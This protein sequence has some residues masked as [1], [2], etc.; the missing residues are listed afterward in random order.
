MSTLAQGN[1]FAGIT[2]TPSETLS[3]TGR[4]KIAI[5]GKPKAGKST[6]AT[7]A[8]TP[9]L[10]YDWDDRPESLAGKPGL[11]VKSRRDMMEVET[12]LS[13]LKAAHKQ[14][15]PL[16]A[17]VVHDSVTYLNKAME[18]EIFRQCKDFYKEIKVGQSTTVKIRKGW[19]TINGIQ[20]YIQYLIAEY[21]AL[22]LDLIFVFHEKN[23][24]DVVE[25]TAERTE[26][27]GQLTTDPQYLSSCLSLFNEVY[28]IK[29]EPN[30]NFVTECRPNLYGNWSTTLMLDKVE[31]PNIM[32]MIEKHESKRAALAAKGAGHGV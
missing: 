24:K 11:L 23:E 30:G 4:L 20:R 28:H 21:T 8:R 1:P 5:V 16:P 2:G 18:E 31:P 12:D 3:P 22:D 17:T 6:L 19:D 10:Y 7:T 14:G 15:K 29:V 9:M 32:K 26:Y 25:S 13:I 27:T